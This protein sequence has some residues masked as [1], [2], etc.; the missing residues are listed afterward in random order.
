MKHPL[1]AVRAVAL[2]RH[3]A[4]LALLPALAA[5]S[6]CLEVP[7]RPP[8]DAPAVRELSVSDGI[9]LEMGC[10]PSGKELC[11]DALDNNCNGLID[12][13]CGLH[14]GLLQFTIAWPERSADVD[15]L[16][17]GPD[18][19]VA[20]R[21][22]PTDSGLLKDRDCPGAEQE[23]RGQ[24]VENVFLAEGPV[25]R[26]RYRVTVRLED[27]GEATPPVRVRLSARIGQRHYS[28]LLSL[29]ARDEQREIE[30]A[31]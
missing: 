12:E 27:L 30:L 11:F 10:T 19:D 15:L 24:N 31:L 2:P 22:Q 7:R 26:G 5:A 6:A 25:R 28:A 16:V 23:C 3:A 13:G 29:Q 14:S 9:E 8:P 4:L 18:G 21:D 17:S 20:R 1:S